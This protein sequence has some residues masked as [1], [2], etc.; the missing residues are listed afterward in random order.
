MIHTPNYVYYSVS[1]M[2]EYA[3]I[4]RTYL[5]NLFLVAVEAEKEIGAIE[6]LTFT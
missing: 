2:F 5:H 3:V 4:I 6:N 1:Q